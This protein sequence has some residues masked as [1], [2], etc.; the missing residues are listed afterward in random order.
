M[1]DL[2]QSDTVPKLTSIVSESLPHLKRGAIR[3]FINILKEHRYFKEDS[4]NRTDRIYTFENGSQIEFF[5]ADQSDKFRGPRRDRLF[6]NEANNI[7]LNAFDQLEVRTRENIWLDWNPTSEFWFYTDVMIQREHDLDHITLTYLDNEALDESTIKAIESRR[8]NKNWWKVY[9]EG[10]LGEVESRV[11]TG[12]QIIEDIPHEARLE[13]RGLD[14]GYTND[15][16][17]IVDIYYY[18]GGYIFD[19]VVYQKGLGNKAIADAILAMMQPSTLVRPDSAEPKS[20]DELRSYGVNVLPCT[21]GPGSI[22]QGIQYIQSQRISVTKR[23]IN[24]IKEYRNYLWITNKDGITINEAQDYNNPCLDAARYGM[25]Q[26]REY[27]DEV[28]ADSYYRPLS[29]D[30]GY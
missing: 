22:N 24:L 14:Y 3:E 23:S 19:E 18:N 1:I 13:R 16:T 4:W 7:T 21:K 10:Q 27:P 26:L 11:Y 9:G 29:T 12:W 5:G 28:H 6:I 20:N 17:T 25:E 8:S 2:A 15:P 30:T